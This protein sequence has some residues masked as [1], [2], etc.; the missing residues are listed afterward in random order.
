LTD[1]QALGAWNKVGDAATRLINRTSSSDGF[2]V[3]PGSSLA[4]DDKRSAPYQVSHAASLNLSASADHLHALCTLVLE[5]QV[6]YVAALA[7]LAR[8]SLETSA[9]ALWILAPMDRDERVTRALK[10][11]VKDIKDGDT[12]AIGAG[13]PVPAAR[14]DR[15]DKV[16]ALA[17]TQGLDWGDVR[18]GYTSSEAV[19]AAEAA[20]KSGLGAVLPWRL[21]SGFAHGRPWAYL[22]YSELE[23][24]A[25]ADPDIVHVQMTSDLKRSLYVAWSSAILLSEAVAMF[26]A[27]AASLL[28]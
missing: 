9:T 22:G 5:A 26:D 13:V 11:H 24:L 1:D 12:A 6:L 17:L 15:L 10:W 20:A 14:Q 2:S 27:R 23:R 18:K 21:C 16:E 19:S 28:P 4:G 7:T 8:G 25:T 3:D